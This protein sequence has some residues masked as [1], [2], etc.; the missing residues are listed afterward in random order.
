MALYKVDSTHPHHHD[1]KPCRE[2]D[3]VSARIVESTMEECEGPEGGAPDVEN[4]DSPV[5]EL[6]VGRAP[7]IMVE[8]YWLK[9]I[10][11]G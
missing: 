10:E 11:Q 5:D 9:S 6:K 8:V 2:E 3:E 4:S 1:H 7:V